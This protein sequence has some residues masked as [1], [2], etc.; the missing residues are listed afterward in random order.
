[1]SLLFKIKENTAADAPNRSIDI[2]YG[3]MDSVLVSL[4]CPLDQGNTYQ[5]AQHELALAIRQFMEQRDWTQVQDK[6]ATRN[7]TVPDAEPEEESSPLM[8]QYQHT[9][10]ATDDHGNPYNHSVGVTPADIMCSNDCDVCGE[11]IAPDSELRYILADI[12]THL[13]EGP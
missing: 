12:Y 6:I 4:P 10:Q 2:V 11:P 7:L 9:C 8:E 13:T 3:S 5:L 1:M